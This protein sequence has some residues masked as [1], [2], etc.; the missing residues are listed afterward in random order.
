MSTPTS[1][2][3]HYVTYAEWADDF[4]ARCWCRGNNGTPGQWCRGC[5]RRWLF[6]DAISISLDHAESAYREARLAGAAS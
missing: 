2:L 1:R 6:V 4:N 3:T 5:Q